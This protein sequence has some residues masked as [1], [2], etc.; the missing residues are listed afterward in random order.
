MSRVVD[1]TQVRH[2]DVAVELSD[3]ELSADR[4]SGGSTVL[5]FRAKGQRHNGD[6]SYVI[7]RVAAMLLRQDASLVRVQRYHESSK[8][9]VVGGKVT[10]SHELYDAE[11]AG[12]AAVFYVVETRLQV[13]RTLLRCE[14]GSVDVIAE[15][16]IWP[17]VS[18]RVEHSDLV[19]VDVAL[20]TRRGERVDISFTAESD[21]TNRG[22]S[23]AAEFYLL[24]GDGIALTSAAVSGSLV[25]GFAYEKADTGIDR[26]TARDIRSMEVRARVD[27]AVVS[28]IGPIKIPAECR[29]G[30]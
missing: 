12:A 7:E 17:I 4:T 25:N 29:I 30:Q 11:L 14:L 6:G 27:V 5:R 16:A 10:W 28:E 1:P 22:L 26:A 8:P 20:S 9:L 23:V 24:D 13:I 3:A 19:H 2:S 15:S 21:V 18:K